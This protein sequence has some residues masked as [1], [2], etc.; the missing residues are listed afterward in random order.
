MVRISSFLPLHPRQFDYTRHLALSDLCI[1]D[2]WFSV[3]IKWAKNLQN[4][5]DQFML[6]V[7]P[8]WD[9]VIC[10]VKNLSN[11]LAILDHT[12]PLFV[13]PGD[14]L[15]PLSIPLACSWFR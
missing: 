14:K 1:T 8:N 4:S 15:I 11:Y 9:S 7:L 13:V 2:T 12:T 5:R 6:P 3:R 10:P